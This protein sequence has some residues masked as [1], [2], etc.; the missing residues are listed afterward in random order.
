MAYLFQI[1]FQWGWS[2]QEFQKKYPFHDQDITKGTVVTFPPFRNH[3]YHALEGV[4]LLLHKLFSA[5][6]L[7]Y[8]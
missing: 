6:E 8:V 5:E 7:P 1:G 3:I 4:G 2:I